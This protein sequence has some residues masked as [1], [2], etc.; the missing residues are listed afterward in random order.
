MAG[1]ALVEKKASKKDKSAK[2]SKKDKKAKKSKPST[3]GAR[4]RVMIF[5]EYTATSF[6]KW[7]GKK[8]Y[9]GADGRA[10]ADKFADGE[11]SNSSIFTAVSDGKNKKYNGNAAEVSKEHA[12]KVK[13]LVGA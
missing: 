7:M 2:A 13:K 10:V 1:V 11:L 3:G 9:N 6:F 12:A 8:G 5:D 4:P